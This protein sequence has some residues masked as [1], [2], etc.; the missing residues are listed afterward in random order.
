MT[1]VADMFDEL[2]FGSGFWIGFIIICAFCFGIAY[3]FKYAGVVSECVFF[4]MAL[5]YFD[6]LATN[7]N[8]LWGAI[9][10]FVSMILVATRLY[11]DFKN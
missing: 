8:Y 2:L 10:C 5:L 11:G 9:M 4:F 6:E 7:S 1:A 3:K